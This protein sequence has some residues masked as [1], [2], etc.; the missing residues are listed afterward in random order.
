M[1]VTKDQ[2][3]SGGTIMG[4]AKSGLMVSRRVEGYWYTGSRGCLESL[5]G[6]AGLLA[7][8]GRGR[9]LIVSAL[10]VTPPDSEQSVTDR[11]QKLGSA[12]F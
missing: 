12:K 4:L 5:L 7:E 10:P 3:V 1:G 8:L 9:P 2:L 11:V 6:D